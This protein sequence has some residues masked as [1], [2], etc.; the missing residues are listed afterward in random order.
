[1]ITI[2][3][4]IWRIR[5][6]KRERLENNNKDNIIIIIKKDKMI[7]LLK[8]NLCNSGKWTYNNKCT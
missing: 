4:R 1:M 7:I 2:R 3:N 8:R 5:N 6:K